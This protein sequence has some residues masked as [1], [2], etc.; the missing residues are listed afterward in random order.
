[1]EGQQGCGYVGDGCGE[2]QVSVSFGRFDKDSLSWEK[3]SSFSPN[4]YLEEVEKCATP[5]SVARKAAYF[6]AHYRRIA[7]RKAEL[8]LLASSSSSS[9]GTDGNGA[10]PSVMASSREILE[11]GYHSICQQQEEE[12][13]QNE[14]DMITLEKERLSFE[15]VLGESTAGR[16]A[17]P[18]ERSGEE[19]DEVSSVK[20]DL[21]EE[22]EEEI[23]A[24]SGSDAVDAAKRSDNGREEAADFEF[25][26][27]NVEIKSAVRLEMSARIREDTAK[28]ESWRKPHK[29]PT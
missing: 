24:A 27:E 1:M 21:K 23:P 4:K 2:L 10:P 28:L 6:E 7:A 17:D 26:S 18:F 3:W 22:E 5:G 16:V 12:E 9:N 15:V 25:S 14:D 11:E 8:L 13:E 19:K 20:D 29:V